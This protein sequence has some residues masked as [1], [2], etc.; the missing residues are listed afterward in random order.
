MKIQHLNQQWPAFSYAIEDFAE[1][2]GLTR[3]N[4]VCDHVAL[5]INDL[6]NAQAL[7]TQLQQY[8][9]IISDSMINGRPI[10]IIELWQALTLGMWSID[11]VE[12][13]FPN[14]PY[15]QQGWE[16]IE[17]ILPGNA[18]T[19]AELEQMLV[20]LSPDIMA[21]STADPA[22]KIKRS[23]PQAS[24]EKLANPTIAFQRAGIC[25]KVH[26]AGIKAVI[27][28]ELAD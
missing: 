3:A 17:L 20:G 27:A 2:L 15:P 9:T 11:C 5:R 8:G 13:P 28:S 19:L 24:G 21:L 26:S 25:I 4:L 14:K 18:T 16:H 6:D 22:I 7:L 23:Q 10:Y 12:L 1:H